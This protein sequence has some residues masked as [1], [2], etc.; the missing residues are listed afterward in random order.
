MKRFFWSLLLLPLL[1]HSQITLPTTPAS[2]KWHRLQTPHFNILY[3]QGF[4]TQAQ[5]TANTLETIYEPEARTM[6]VLPR[7]INLLLQNQT[8][9][10]NGFVTLGPRR[11]E[12]FTMPPQNY[13]FLGNNDWLDLLAVHEY[14][15]VAQFQRSVTGINRL[16]YYA[17][18]QQTL[19]ALSFVA[20]PQWFWEGDAVAIETAYTPSG[21]GRIPHFNMLFRVNALEGR[22]FNYH[23]QYLRS[24][25]H[26]IPNHYVLGYEMVGYLRQKTND[27][28]IWE[29]IAKRAWGG[30]IIPF[31][32]S[33]AIKK[34]AGLTITQLYNEMAVERQRQWQAQIDSLELTPFQSLTARRNRTYTD[35]EF[36]QV[37][38]DGRILAM[39]SGLADIDQLVIIGNKTRTFV[40]GILNSAGMLSH[41]NGRIV[42]NEYRFDPRWPMR[43]Y[44][45]VMAY[46][47]NTQRKHQVTRQ[48]RYAGAALSPDGQ[49]V[50]TIETTE[51]YQTHLVLLDYQTGATV[52]KF[53]NPA[54]EFYAMP[55]WDDRGNLYVLRNTNAGK[56]IVRLNTATGEQTD[57]FTPTRE[58]I[59]APMPVG[60]YVLYNS[61]RSGIDN[62]YALDTETGIHYQVTQAKYGAYNGVA[63]RDG[64]Q[65]IYAHQTRD[66]K[67]I[68]QMPFDPARWKVVEHQSQQPSTFFKH[69]VEQEGHPDIL[70]NMATQSYPSQRYPRIRGMLN[71]H[72]WGAF[73][74]N[75]TFTQA[76]VGITSKDVLNTTE[77]YGGYSFDINERTGSWKARVSYQG[78]YPILDLEVLTGDRKEET[79]VL[80]RE[81][82]LRWNETTV[83]GGIR[84]PFNFTHS[85]YFT[86]LE[87]G[88]QV[89]LT[90][91]RAFS[92]RV[93]EGG[94][95]ITERSG[96]YVLANDTLAYG[97]I[98]RP[99]TGTL[100]A[101]RFSLTFS[102][103]LKTSPR[104]FQPRWGQFF[105]FE[106]FS[107]PF[108][109]DFRGR[110]TAL[111]AGLY[112]P[113][114]ARQHSILLR[115]NTQAALEDIDTD[116][117]AFRNRV[118]RPRGYSYPRDSRFTSFSANY[119]LPLWYPDIALGPLLNIQRIKLNAFLDWG[120]GQGRNYFYRIN[121]NRVYV[122]S[123]DAT[124]LS[125]GGEV[126]VDFNLFRFLPKFEVGT[127]V[128]YL[129]ANRFFNSGLV[130]EFIIGNIGF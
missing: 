29:R 6:G 77:I 128:T 123:A 36:P 19:A 55:A 126:T 129:T 24:Y 20:A 16:A 114:V 31:T 22:S 70:R 75:T 1:A 45:V 84:L 56:T 32:F 27:P 106:H 69:L 110:L 60:K 44:S 62:I 53:D 119:A 108:K 89:Q 25:K 104:D 37:L 90:D 118:F 41:A 11:S 61:P 65:L 130:T 105:A 97:F 52:K 94:T 35:Y 28:M 48:S 117:Y 96:R 112:L 72:S 54:N 46:D 80:G 17:F 58:N 4:E 26:N 14:R 34:E 91:V 64:R 76:D 38:E 95:L 115:F 120:Q 5:R 51:A 50:A 8:A 102:N 107:T 3:P 121:S 63:S 68:V 42:W 13:N 98:D 78:A 87:V 66:G 40:P 83:S 7:R 124:Y 12:F 85:K 92:H 30:S 49:H 10:S 113:G 21:R 109:S 67:D 86:A 43:T 15:H 82:E 74:N 33:S 93:T 127:R 125:L 122:S 23:K 101:N 79:G 39:K 47:L 100:V 71:P 57:L 111:R 99:E 88:N 116:V 18:G 2:V 81:V 9:I 73:F 103:L 59:G